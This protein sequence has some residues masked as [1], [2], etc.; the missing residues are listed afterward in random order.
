MTEFTEKTMTD[1][2][3]HMSISLDGYVAGPGQSLT[4]G[5]GIRGQELHAWHMGDPRANDADRTAE[6][7]LMRPR[8]AYVMGRNMFGPLRGEWD[9]PWEGW[10]GAEP[11]YRAPVF[12]LTHHPHEPIEMSG[13]TTFHFVTEGFDTAYAL[14]SAAAAGRGVDIAGGASTVRQALAAGVVDELVLDIAP[15]LLG[16]GERL[17][18]GVGAFGFAPVEALHSPLATHIRYRRVPH[19]RDTQ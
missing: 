2:T 16:A 8:G 3:C 6:S 12:V 7:W 14:A 17:F 5:L 13:G 18:D 1:T 9:E 4:A 15:V 19:G 10:W 11:P